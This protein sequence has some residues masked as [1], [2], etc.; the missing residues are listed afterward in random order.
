[1]CDILNTNRDTYTDSVKAIVYD[2][3]NRDDNQMKTI[4]E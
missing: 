4:E 3:L 1:M 2:K